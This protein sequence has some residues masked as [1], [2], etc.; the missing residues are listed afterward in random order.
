MNQNSKH[1][2]LGGDIDFFI[3]STVKDY[4]DGR[5]RVNLA[6]NLCVLDIVVQ[7]DFW[8]TTAGSAFQGAAERKKLFQ[9]IKDQNHQQQRQREPRSLMTPWI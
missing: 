7:V 2:F 9:L 3:V 1:Q 8:S 4:I 5:N 6:T